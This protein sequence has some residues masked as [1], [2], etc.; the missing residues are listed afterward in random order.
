MVIVVVVFQWTVRILVLLTK[1]KYSILK[2]IFSFVLVNLKHSFVWFV[3]E[4]LLLLIVF[5]QGYSV[6][7]ASFSFFRESSEILVGCSFF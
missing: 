2:Y 6:I 4:L 3:I 5:F 7:L 1:S